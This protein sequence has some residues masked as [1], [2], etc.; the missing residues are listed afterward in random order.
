VE[1]LI[2]RAIHR[3]SRPLLAA[4]ALLAGAAAMTAADPA[5]VSPAPA[6]TEVEVERIRPKEPKLPS[7]TFLRENRDFIRARF[8][9]LRER[10]AEG[11]GDAV[12]FDPRWL[13]WERMLAAIHAARESVAFVHN[14][15]ERRQ[16]LASITELGR[17]EDQL[18]AMDRQLALQS[19]RLRVL[20]EDFTGAQRTALMVVLSGDPGD[21]VVEVA[22]TLEGGGRL[23][24]PLYVEQREALRRGGVVQVFHGFVEPRRQVIEIGVAGPP[25][26]AGDR[27]YVTLEPARDR[28]TFL[29]LAFGAG[30]SAESAPSA[31]RGAA[32]IRAFTWLHEPKRSPA[33]G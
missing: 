10:P 31:V 15:V 26:P 7:L 21:D 25:W 22:V 14:D 2:M 33:G 6:A 17:L 3:V 13:A 29:R 1:G 18:D 9:L 24:V 30:A 28:L 32:S 5:P 4:A 27:G 20:E 12:A 11:R 16:L 23:S 8:D 19:E